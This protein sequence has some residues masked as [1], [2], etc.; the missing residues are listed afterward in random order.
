MPARL[1]VFVNGQ[2]LQSSSVAFGSLGS[3]DPGDY[4]VAAP[5]EETEVKFTFDLEADD[6]VSVIVR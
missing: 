3:S 4:S 2:L 5:V 6:T 1:D